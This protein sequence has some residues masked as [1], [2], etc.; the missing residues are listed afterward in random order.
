MLPAAVGARFST[1]CLTLRERTCLKECPIC[2]RASERDPPSP[3]PLPLS[4]HLGPG[5]QVYL[6][7][8]S[9]SSSPGDRSMSPRK[10]LPRLVTNVAGPRWM[11]A[12]H[13]CYFASRLK[14]TLRLHLCA[15]TSVRARSIG[16]EQN[17]VRLPFLNVCCIP[18][19]SLPSFPF[20]AIRC[21]I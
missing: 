15:W 9:P 17:Y 10:G 6:P 7:S 3:L 21:H 5:V 12:P 16:L 19:H 20:L 2:R 4:L 13:R 14:F 8:A 18:N 11:R 1:V